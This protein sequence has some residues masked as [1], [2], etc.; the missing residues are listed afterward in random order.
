[1]KDGL[2]IWALGLSRHLRALVG[3][4]CALFGLLLI[5]GPLLFWIQGVPVGLS[6]IV[7]LGVGLVALFTG[8]RL[9]RRISDRG[10]EAS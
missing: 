6:R 10:S 1:M 7:G 2:S 9:L 5:A 3:V 8:V 4:I